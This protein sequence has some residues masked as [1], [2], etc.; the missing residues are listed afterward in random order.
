MPKFV[1]FFGLTNVLSQSKYDNINKAVQKKWFGKPNQ[2][3]PQ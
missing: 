2:Y 1:F 3:T